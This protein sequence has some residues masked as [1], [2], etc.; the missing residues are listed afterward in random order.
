VDGEGPPE[1][2]RPGE[3]ARLFRVKVKTVVSW[4]NE[5]KL[6][7]VRTVGGHRRFFADE[8]RELLE[9]EDPR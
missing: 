2:L 4:A 7:T 5:G 9:R 8:V 6:Q 3:V 1:L